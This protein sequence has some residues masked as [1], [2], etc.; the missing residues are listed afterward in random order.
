MYTHSL[1]GLKTKERLHD[2]DPYT[3]THTH[4][5]TNTHKRIT[6]THKHKQARLRTWKNMKDAARQQF[7]WP[8]PGDPRQEA[9]DDS[10]IFYPEVRA[11]MPCLNGRKRVIGR[12]N[13]HHPLHVQNVVFRVPHRI[14]LFAAL[15]SIDCGNKTSATLTKAGALPR[16]S[17]GHL[18][19]GSC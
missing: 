17:G 8:N 11:C 16:G 7:L 5:Q 6:H 1:I 19:P 12:V 4:T 3:H 10:D 14:A 18:L 15:H 9:V 2:V 13:A